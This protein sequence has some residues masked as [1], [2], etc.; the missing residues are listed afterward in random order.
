MAGVPVHTAESPQFSVCFQENYKLDGEEEKVAVGGQLGGLQLAL[1]QE[2]RLQ[3]V[4]LLHQNPAVCKF[5]TFPSGC[6]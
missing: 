5:R 3:A 2:G 6:E 1:P 4:E